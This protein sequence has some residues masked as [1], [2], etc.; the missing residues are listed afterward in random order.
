MRL[1]T[2]GFEEVSAQG[3]LALT[4][5][6]NS[7]GTVNIATPSP[8]RAQTTKCISCPTSVSSWVTR[9]LTTAK[10][11]GKLYSRGYVC[12]TDFGGAANSFGALFKW[13]NAGAN[14]I[15]IRFN[16]STKKFQLENNATGAAVTTTGTFV[17]SLNTWYRVELEV[18]LATDTAGSATC[19]VY[20]GDT[21]TLLD[22]LTLSAQKTIDA[23][24]QPSLSGLE[25]GNRS[26]ANWGTVTIDDVAINDDDATSGD[27]QT[28]WCGAGCIVMTKPAS[29]NGASNPTQW[30]K[31]GSSPAATNSQGV[32]DLPGTPNDGTDYNYT[33]DNVSYDRFDMN[34]LPGGIVAASFTLIDIY[35]RVGGNSTSTGTIDLSVWDDAGFRTDAPN[36]IF[37]SAVGWQI[38]RTSEHL[39]F[40]LSGKTQTQVNLFDCGY[41]S[42]GGTGIEKRVSALWANVEYVPDT[43]VSVSRTLTSNYIVLVAPTQ[44]R[45]SNYAVHTKP[46]TSQVSNHESVSN[47]VTST[48]TSPWESKG[49]IA[50]SQAVIHRMEILKG[51]TQSK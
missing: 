35:A 28:T 8:A 20:S 1:H 14:A 38:T 16:A 21:S 32:D 10:T 25:L 37:I 4:M 39:C 40:S 41:K 31:G 7:N 11:T 5:W 50:V 44:S 15:V 26:G 18:V 17:A 45:T 36:R 6:T 13:S 22:T 19:K 47:M 30:T 29:T 33:S 3:D 9:S 49:V 27:G 46:T 51:V 43:S 48:K 24:N 34:N 12:W 42:V 23:T 2:C